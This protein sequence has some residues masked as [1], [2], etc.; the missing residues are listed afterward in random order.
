VLKAFPAI[1]RTPLRRLERNGRFFCALRANC[2][3]F[4][5]LATASGRTPARRAVRFACFAPLRLVLEALVGEK[6]LLARREYKLGRT[7]GAL[8]DPIVVFHTLLQSTSLEY[9]SGTR[10][11]RTN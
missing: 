7:F 10:L 3:G 8:Q 4:Y 11:R 2:L 6:H 1:D 5:A 9:G